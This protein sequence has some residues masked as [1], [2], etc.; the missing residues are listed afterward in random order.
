MSQSFKLRYQ[1]EIVGTFVLVGIALVFALLLLMARSQQWFEETFQCEI[2]FRSGNVALISDG[3]QLRIRSQVIG[4]VTSSKYDGTSRLVVKAAIGTRYRQAVHKDTEAVLYTPIAG[5]PGEPYI[6]LKGGKSPDP[7]AEGA[8]LQ[9]RAAEDLLQLATDVL[10][11]TQR[12]LGPTLREVH[13]LTERLNLAMDALAKDNDPVDTALAV[14]RLGLRLEKSLQSIERVISGLERVMDS[15]EKGEGVVNKMLTDPKM[16][17]QVTTLIEATRNAANGLSRS[18]LIA[19]QVAGRASK[20]MAT[21]TDFMSAA[22][23]LRQALPSLIRDG[24]QTLND[25]AVVTS[26]LRRVAPHVPSLASQVD[27]VLLET[28]NVLGAAERHWLF[29]GTLRP[30]KPAASL[31]VRG[32]RDTPSTP[33]EAGLRE[34]LDAKPSTPSTSGATP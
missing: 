22:K 19:N 8:V 30:T 23:P 25:L 28:R 12:H 11:D 2:R 6:E 29:N 5:L 7:I 17:R 3:M 26:Q 31:P 21:S 24:K 9:G 14:A 32:L 15:V 4:Q 1:N 20:L 13:R 10:T 18:L 34:L 16:V 33:A 27:E